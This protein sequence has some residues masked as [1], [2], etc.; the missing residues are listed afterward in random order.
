[1]IVH[2]ICNSLYKND[3]SGTGAKMYGGRWNSKGVEMLY[4]T[5]YI[6][7]AALEML[8]H[9]RFKDF[10]IPLSLIHISLP[11]TE[12]REVKL[13]KLKGNWITDEGYTRFMGD[14]F[15]RGGKS[16]FIKVPSVVV[17]EE[18]NYLVNPQHEDF[19]KIKITGVRN[20]ETDKRLFTL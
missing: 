18:H 2:R 13:N 14:E 4:V 7:L 19:K 1:M 5:E 9:N 12:G 11:E 3:L 10:S 8:V 20:F 6:S 15:I 16:L 17:N